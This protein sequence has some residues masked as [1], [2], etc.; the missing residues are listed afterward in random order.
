MEN[1]NDNAKS[2]L[3]NAKQLAKKHGVDVLGWNDK[4]GQEFISFNG[5]GDRLNALRVEMETQGW[6]TWPVDESSEGAFM[7]FARRPPPIGGLPKADSP[8]I[9]EVELDGSI[10]VQS[11]YHYSGPGYLFRTHWPALFLLC[12]VIVGG[13]QRLSFSKRAIIATVVFI[14]LL[15]LVLFCDW[16]NISAANGELVI[17]KHFFGTPKSTDVSDIKS[18]KIL[19]QTVGY[20]RKKRTTEFVAIKLKSGKSFDLFL[21][22][23]K[24]SELVAWIRQH[25]KSTL[26]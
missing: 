9:K 15:G 23:K 20:R 19:R 16:I 1:Y 21:P 10:A 4:P 24:Q 12:I 3:A 6:Y 17:C 14:V 13:Q 18:A 2:L 11:T 8:G 5:E 7:D 22:P 26:G 25:I